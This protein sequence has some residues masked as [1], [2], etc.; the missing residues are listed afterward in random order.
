MDFY[1]RIKEIVGQENIKLNE[2]MSNYTTFRIGGNADYIVTPSNIEQIRRIILISNEYK[3]QYEVIG[4]GSNILVS[5]DGFR[6]IIINLANK[7]SDVQIDYNKENVLV[8]AKSGIMLSKLSLIMAENGLSGFE[9]AS[10]IPGTLGGAVTMN[11]GAYGGEIKDFIKSTT[12]IDKEGNIFTIDKE[13]LKMS[14]RNSV[15]KQEGYIVLEATFLMQK[16][17]NK[18]DILEKMNELNRQR[19]EKQPLNYPSAGSTF[20]R[21]K[22]YFAGKLIMDSGLRGYK[23]GDIMISEKHCGFVVNIGNGTAKQVCKLISDV[24]KQ[25]YTKFGVHL[26]PEIKFLGF[27]TEDKL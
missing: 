16:N 20:K 2:P 10:G 3:I 19:R 27:D 14:Y 4:N 25:V 9:F 1:N 12:V 7:F 26:E 18:D 15:I 21:P 24:Q 6:G 5:D 11:A 17:G 22:G 23:V 8:K 13:N